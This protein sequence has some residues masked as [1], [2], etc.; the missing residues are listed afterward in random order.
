[1]SG[2]LGGSSKRLAQQP[3]AAG[4]L[5]VQTSSYG[6][7]VPIVYGVNRIACNII[8]YGGFTAI[9]HTSSAGGAGGKGLGGG[10]SS[11]T[12]SY[13]YSCWVA[14]ALCE[15]GIWNT[16]TV[17]ASKS[18]TSAYTLGAEVHGGGDGQ[19]PSGFLEATDPSQA[20][21]Y[22]GTA[23]MLVP[24]YDLGSNPDLPSHSAEVKR[25]VG[26]ALAAGW[27]DVNP[28][29][30]VIDFL[31][32][33]RYGA[34]FPSASIGDLS[35]WRQYC[36]S[37]NCLMSPIW[38][39]QDTAANQLTQLI[40]LTNSAPF[41]SEGL[42][43]IVPYGDTAVS[44]DG[45]SWAP[46]LTPV[47][48]L[49][50]DDFIVAGSGDGSDPVTVARATLADANNVVQVEY[51]DRANAY[52]V[53]VAEAQ[54][55]AAV[56]LYGKRVDT[57]RKAHH[58]T[59]PS[60]ASWTAQHLLQ[61]QVY[62]RN[63]YGFTLGWRYCLLEPM[64]LVTLTDA[65]LGLDRAL[66]RI[67]SI[68]EDKGGALTVAA[69]EMP[70][71]IATAALYPRQT[72][73]GYAADYNADP[74]PVT[75]VTFFEPPDGVADGLQVW[76]AI[77]GA[78]SLWGGCDVWVSRDGTSYKKA[79]TFAGRSR[80]GVLSAD[81]S[82][83]SA[84]DQ[85]NTLA[86]DL[87]ESG[88]TLTGGTVVEARALDT[89]CYVG[90]EYL[91][92]ETATL[93]AAGTYD[94]TYLVRGAY[95]SAI[96]AHAAGAAF[97]RLDGAVFE[98]DFD[99]SDIGQTIYVKF[100]S[101]NSFGSHGGQTLAG[102]PAYAYTLKGSALASPL[103]DVTGLTSTF[104]D[105]FTTL[106]WVAVS[107]FRQVDYEIRRG[108]SWASAQVLGRTATARWVVDAD[109]IYWV[110]AHARPT[111]GLDVYSETP[112]E[113]EIAGAV[114]VRNVVA[115][116]DEAVTG[117]VGTVSGGAVV[118]KE[119][120]TLG[121][122]GNL[123]DSP[124]LL[125]ETDL[126]YLGGVAGE[127]YYQIPASHQVDIGR[128]AACAIKLNVSA[129]AVS[130]HDNLLT[131]PDLLSVTNLLGSADPSLI[132][133]TPE[134]AL[135][136]SPGMFGPWAPFVPGQYN[137]RIFALRLC[138]RSFDPQVTPVV[139]AFN[140]TIDVPDRVDTGT[141]ISVPA[142][143]L[144]VTYTSP[145]NDVPNVQVTILDAVAGDILALT[146][147]S[148]ASFTMQITNGGS[149]VARTVNWAAQGY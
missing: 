124:N 57:G 126:L 139:T 35:S 107:D 74:G 102:V 143:G 65:A 72:G 39:S 93:T 55:Q 3:Q 21:S 149:G 97:V 33:E 36:W 12:T 99:A 62:V 89:L 53:S 135:A 38:D 100:V 56:E 51:V 79:G 26:S 23:Y 73:T 63:T 49:T 71:G 41:W 86:V 28:A 85:T 30:A 69:E 110:C 120:L 98:Y 31:T 88:G 144:T 90:G 134:V 77:A 15:G 46:D 32:A 123:L 140:F 113:V 68:A 147:R 67:T 114:L 131:V 75:S 20:L 132:A 141:E 50:D 60:V 4:A 103:P 9:P 95:G 42:L 119:G 16:G 122:A 22:S 118:A 11:G 128:V 8:A 105:G 61:R 45:A 25:D 142:A 5:R 10:A 58:I 14:L 54:D 137:A 48:D 148:A 109:G 115:T 91:A 121:G 44:G 146:G 27:Q 1:M 116:W 80:M 117:F 145:F 29:D 104:V 37:V 6:Q 94:L 7:V 108:G 81:L 19:P 130:I 92:Y 34:G 13:T 96:D 133:V 76:V 59:Q 47:Y 127:G 40:E 87:T 78:G 112:A 17:W 43:K 129:E 138:L 136:S 125:A 106:Q 101:F 84:I 66:V 24:N 70:E 83:G 82:A 18:V 52:N 111:T 64:D 2:L